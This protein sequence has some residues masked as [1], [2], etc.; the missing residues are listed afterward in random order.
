MQVLPPLFL[1]A[2]SVRSWE[3]RSHERPPE[4]PKPPNLPQLT[5]TL[6]DSV[7]SI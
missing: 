6:V 4:P 3:P 5:G 2:I 1:Y 7:A